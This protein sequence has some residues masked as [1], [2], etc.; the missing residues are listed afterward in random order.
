[1]A[2]KFSLL[3]GGIGQAPGVKSLISFTLVVFFFGTNLFSAHAAFSSLYVFGDALSSTTDNPD[4]SYYYNHRYSNGRV[5]VEVLAQRQ[6]LTYDAAKNNS[7]WDHNSGLL[8]NEL[9][10]FKA[11]SDVA[12]ALFIVWVCNADTFDAAQ[13]PFTSLSQWQAANAKS[14]A[15]HLQIIAKL[16]AKGVRNLVLPNAVDISKVPAFNA[17]TTYTAVER[18]GCIDFN[19]EFANTIRQARELYPDLKIYTPDYFTLLNNVL[20]NADYYGLT[21]ALSTRGFSIDAI[22]DTSIP[23]LT[24]NGR[25]T[26]Y[27]FWDPQNPTAKFHAVIADVAQ[28]L[29]SPV[30]ISKL[31]V[32]AGSNRLDLINVPVGLGGFIDGVTV[33]NQTQ[34]EWCAVKSFSSETVT[35]SLFVSPPQFPPFLA[36]PTNMASGGSID[37]NGPPSTNAPSGFVQTTQVQ[38]YGLRF[39]FAWSWP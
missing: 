11:P 30:Q 18:A 8:V 34:A 15:N 17:G 22:E 36:W 33:T 12:T 19:L 13:T 25:G 23:N 2:E 16:Y 32:F 24:L 9:N 28:Q 35:K 21:N 7:Y 38:F 10:G 1:M 20:T 3:C 14:Q 31:T 27:I 5:W 4:P 6:G 26:N 29:I 39:P 37:P